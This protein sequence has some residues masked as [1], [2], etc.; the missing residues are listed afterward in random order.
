M[1]RSSSK[2]SLAPG[3]NEGSLLIVSSRTRAFDSFSKSGCLLKS[4]FAG[5]IR[6]GPAGALYSTILQ[7]RRQSSFAHADPDDREN[8]RVEFC[9]DHVSFHK[10]MAKPDIPRKA[11]YRL[12]LYHRG[13]QRLSANQVSTVS[14]AALAKAAG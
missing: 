13:L 6:Q 12:S 8:P 3:D 10:E 11:V 14:S 9:R 4:G 2:R 5:V 7:F 1:A